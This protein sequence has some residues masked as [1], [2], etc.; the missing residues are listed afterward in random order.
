MYEQIAANKRKTAFLIFLFVALLSAVGF[1]INFLFQ[2]GVV[3]LVIVG[4]IVIV[5]SLVS[6]YNSD[7]VALKMSHAVP[8]DP[9]Q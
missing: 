4:I 3:G 9:V 6:Y 1:A 2:G 8:A 7:K 5:S